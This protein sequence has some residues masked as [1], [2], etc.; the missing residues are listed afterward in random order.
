MRLKKTSLDFWKKS[1]TLHFSALIDI[2]I[3]SVFSFLIILIKR[4][5]VSVQNFSTGNKLN[6]KLWFWI[7]QNGPTFSK[8]TNIDT[9]TSHMFDF[10]YYVNLQSNDSFPKNQLCWHSFKQAER[11]HMLPT[12]GPLWDTSGY[13][14]LNKSHPTPKKQILEN[15]KNQRTCY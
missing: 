9:K 3:K 13:P 5:L 2:L 12:I 4:F 14:T 1:K 10:R 15:N 11:Y 7:F 6:Q 8:I